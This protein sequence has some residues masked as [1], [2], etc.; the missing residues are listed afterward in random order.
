M[1]RSAGVV[2][3]QKRTS[4]TPAR[5]RSPIYRSS[6]LQRSHYIQ[7]TVSQNSFQYVY[8]PS[9]FEFIIYSYYGG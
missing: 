4:L 7:T 9:P 1:S 8:K 5:K 2:I 3:A 6:R